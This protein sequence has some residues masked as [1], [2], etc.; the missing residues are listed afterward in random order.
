MPKKIYQILFALLMLIISDGYAQGSDIIVLKKR[1]TITKKTFFAGSQ[2]H[3]ID[4]AGSEVNGVIKK[5]AND[6]L[7][8]NLYDSR[9]QYT[10][11]GTSF[12][13][14]IAVFTSKYH[15]KEIREII[16]P[17]KGFGFIKNGLLFIIGGVGYSFLHTF[18]AI[19]LKEKLDGKT[20]A[21]SGAAVLNG[22]LLKKTHHNSI[23]LGKHYYLQYIPL[24]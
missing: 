8:I 15:Y 18:N 13:D 17:T 10:I 1:N 2:I 4:I 7:Y 3:F 12:L 5:I 14:T 24:K 22:L 6:S 9:R 21:I 23:R 19:Y 16:K 11:W 20:M